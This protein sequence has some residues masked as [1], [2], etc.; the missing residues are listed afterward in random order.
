MSPQD[1]AGIK[2]NFAPMRGFS[3]NLRENEINYIGNVYKFGE[4]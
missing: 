2:L 1:I 3:I 4:T